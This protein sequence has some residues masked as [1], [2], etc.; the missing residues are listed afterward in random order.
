MAMNLPSVGPERLLQ[1]L[2]ALAAALRQDAEA[3][4]L[5]AWWWA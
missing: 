4:G 3:L 1:R 5:L 2:D